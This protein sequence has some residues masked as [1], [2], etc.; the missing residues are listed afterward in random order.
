MHHGPGDRSRRKIA[1]TALIFV[2]PS[3]VEES[4]TISAI[5]NIYRCLDFARHDRAERV[6]CQSLRVQFEVDLHVVMIPFSESVGQWL[7]AADPIRER[8]DGF[9]E[10]A[11]S[12]RPNDL[13]TRN[14][15]VFFDSK[16][17]EHGIF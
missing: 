11:A 4:V 13:E 6:A 17:H 9:V 15:A 3:V 10:I 7:D 2:I 5:G 16:F 8:F 14:P 12:R 1:R